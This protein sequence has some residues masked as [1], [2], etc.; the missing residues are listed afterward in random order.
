MHDPC[1]EYP[2]GYARNVGYPEGTSGH[3][4]CV[5]CLTM[6]A[7]TRLLGL[8]V[9]IDPPREVD[10]AQLARRQR[11]VRRER[12]RVRCDQFDAVA[13]KERHH[14]DEGDAFVAVDIRVITDKSEGIRSGKVGQ[15]GF[16]FVLPSGLRSSER[17]LEGV[18]ITLAVKA[19]VLANL[20]EVRFIYHEPPEPMRLGASHFASS[21]SA[22]R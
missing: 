21:L 3:A 2:L 22:P 18:F 4:R 6:T 15:G 16:T 14:H 5:E 11:K 19:A 7:L 17:Q 1:T 12:F 13:V 20:P 8:N 9:P 10:L